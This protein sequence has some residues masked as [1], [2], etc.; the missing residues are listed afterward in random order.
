MTREEL[1]TA[2]RA[3]AGDRIVS[4]DV[5]LGDGLVREEKAEKKEE[6]KEEKRDEKELKEPA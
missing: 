4:A 5:E 1:L 2:I 6:K 3:Q